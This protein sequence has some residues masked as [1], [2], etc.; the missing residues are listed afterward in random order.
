MEVMNGKGYPIFVIYDKNYNLVERIP[1][2]LCGEGGLTEKYQPDYTEHENVYGKIIIP[3]DD[4]L[5]RILFKLDYSVYVRKNLM[6]SIDRV[7]YYFESNYNN[8]NIRLIP[9]SGLPERNFEVV[10]DDGFEQRIKKQWQ[11][12]Q[13]VVLNFKTKELVKRG[14][15]DTDKIFA[16][17]N[18]GFAKMI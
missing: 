12:H 18:F 10:M 5:Y 2:D 1:L 14:F 13:G 4:K 15:I 8:Y 9:R 7:Y 11:G 3:E 6:V 17:M 16:Y